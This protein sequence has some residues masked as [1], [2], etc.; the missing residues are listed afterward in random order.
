MSELKIIDMECKGNLIRFYLGIDDDYHG[1]DWDDTPYEHN[2]GLVYDEFIKATLDVAV[3]FD[4]DIREASDGYI[5]SPYCKNDFKIA[6]IPYF[7]IYKE[8]D[9][10]FLYFNMTPEEIKKELKDVGTI[11]KETLW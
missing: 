10:R 5:N 7:I 9:K 11:I 8:K 3:D 4:Y 1:D 6:K 2:A